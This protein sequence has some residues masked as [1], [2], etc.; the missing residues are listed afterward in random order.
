[1]HMSDMCAKYLRLIINKMKQLF[2]VSDDLVQVMG[3]PFIGYRA[4][5]CIIQTVP[6]E[7]C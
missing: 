4:L 1:M 3:N 2:V 7:H 6:D 5:L